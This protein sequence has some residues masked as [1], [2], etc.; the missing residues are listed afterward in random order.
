MAI[1]K[2]SGRQL[3]EQWM[4]LQDGRPILRGRT[5]A[6]AEKFAKQLGEGIPAHVAGTKIHSPHIELRYDKAAMKQ[7]DDLYTEFKGYRRGD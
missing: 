2:Y 5:K 7:R 4:V 1:G 6:E 3:E